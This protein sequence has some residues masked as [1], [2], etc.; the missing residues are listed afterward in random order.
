VLMVGSLPSSS[1]VSPER[2]PSGA[3]LNNL[4]MGVVCYSSDFT[5]VP[6]AA[7]LTVCMYRESLK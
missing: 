4:S 5:G 2:P 6:S 3:S 1:I 7:R